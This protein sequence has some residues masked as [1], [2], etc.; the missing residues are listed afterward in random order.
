MKFNSSC[1]IDTEKT[2]LFLIINMFT[3]PER[4]EV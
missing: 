1:N 4:I 3:D 2:K